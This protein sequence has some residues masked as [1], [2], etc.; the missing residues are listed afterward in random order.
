M[1]GGLLPELEST[2]RGKLRDQ[3]GAGT[4]RKT[5]AEVHSAS[6]SETLNEF[7][8]QFQGF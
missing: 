1:A 4:H 2:A 3:T 7:F 6:V 8:P 5:D